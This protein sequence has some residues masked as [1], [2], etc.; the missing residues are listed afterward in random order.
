MQKKFGTVLDEKVLSQARSF[1]Q[2][3]HTTISHLLEMALAEYLEKKKRHSLSSFS[4]VE[5]NF[6]MLKLPAQIL[7]N[8]LEE[9]IYETP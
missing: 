6:G 7:K 8:A 5:A 2:Q 9:D 1:C 4:T 3:E